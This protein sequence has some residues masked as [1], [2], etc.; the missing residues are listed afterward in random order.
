M[1]EENFTLSQ[2]LDIVMEFENFEKNLKKKHYN[3]DSKIA[4]LNNLHYIKNIFCEIF[5]GTLD[6]PEKDYGFADFDN[7][8]LIKDVLTLYSLEYFSKE[9][10]IYFLQNLDDEE[11][12]EKI[13]QRI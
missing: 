13:Y 12:V 9:E 5:I 2:F 11:V 8:D 1:M 10:V 4:L 3:E 7:T 6:I